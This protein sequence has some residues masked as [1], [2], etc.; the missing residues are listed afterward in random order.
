ME[1][2]K[3]QLVEVSGNKLEISQNW[4]QTYHVKQK[5]HAKQMAESFKPTKSF[6]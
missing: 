6:N 2:M 5:I 3:V 1:F 4:H